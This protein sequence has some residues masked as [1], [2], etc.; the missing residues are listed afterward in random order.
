MVGNNY[1]LCPLWRLLK[2]VNCMKKDLNTSDIYARC[3]D[4]IGDVYYLCVSSQHSYHSHTGSHREEKRK[5]W[6]YLQRS[7]IV[8]RRVSYRLSNLIIGLVVN[9][10]SFMGACFFSWNA[11]IF[12]NFLAVTKSLH[13]SSLT[14]WQVQRPQEANPKSSV[15]RGWVEGRRMHV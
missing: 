10:R 3:L 1:S 14:S 4:S 11:C 9:E 7:F 8:T 15:A 6:H 13:Q 12:C 2:A 5:P